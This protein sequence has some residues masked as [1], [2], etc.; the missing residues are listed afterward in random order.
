MCV[1]VCD[2]SHVCVCEQAPTGQL[3][4]T[5]V[6]YDLRDQH[7]VGG[8]VTPMAAAH[9]HNVFRVFVNYGPSQ[10]FQNF[11]LV[12]SGALPFPD[13]C[14]LDKKAVTLTVTHCTVSGNWI[15]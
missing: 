7:P 8:M 13:G 9:S 15:E 1:C 6:S 12:L 14:G 5:Y 4:V 11:T 2:S 3:T 10:L